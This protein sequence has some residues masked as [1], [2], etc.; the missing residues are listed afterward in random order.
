VSGGGQIDALAVAA[1]RE[2]RRFD[3][4]AAGRRAAGFVVTWG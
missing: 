1:H 3:R 2:A 4:F